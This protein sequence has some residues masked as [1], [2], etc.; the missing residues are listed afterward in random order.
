MEL[1]GNRA[2]LYVDSPYGNY[3]AFKPNALPP[4]P[5][6]KYNDRLLDL[7]SQASRSLG[8]LDGIT[9][10]LPNPDLFLIMY[11][12][13][14]AVLSSQIEGTQASLLDVLEF[15]AKALEPDNS[16]DVREVVNYIGA[17]ELG[18]E[19]LKNEGK[20]DL[21]LI[22]MIHKRLM[23][24]VRG[25]EMDPG[26]LR[27]VQNWIGPPDCAIE[28]AYYIPPEPKQMLTS[29]NE[30]EIYING[31]N[32]IPFLLKVGLIHSQFETIH[33]FLDGNGRIGRLL[34]TFLLMK[35][36]Y[37]SRPLLYLSYYFKLHRQE[38]YDRLQAVRDSGAWEEWLEFFLQGIITTSNISTNTSKEIISL[39]QQDQAVLQE[40]LGSRLSNGL[41]LFD[42][43]FNKPIITVN[44]A[45]ELTGLSYQNSNRLL[46]AF[47]H[48]N[49]LNEVTGQKRNRI[50]EYKR[51]VDILND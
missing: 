22:R 26:K 48:F 15:E 38:Y 1:S 17:L 33:P 14:E 2:G 19:R 37:L 7:L 18:L 29:L 20:I 8:R 44:R 34:I 28:D 43:L 9:E 31:L 36:K 40:K 24:D 5:S 13:K 51:Y 27:D 12:K 23:Q 42:E 32:Q 6:I 39:R 11:I 16:S 3:K 47:E 21:D 25:G 10:V 45:V 41:I 30:L 49:I 46:S 50:Y 35:Q 4:D